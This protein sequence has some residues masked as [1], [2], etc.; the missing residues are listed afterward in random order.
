MISRDEAA[1]EVNFGT[2]NELIGDIVA[3]R[4]RGMVTSWFAPWDNMIRWWGVQ[5]AMMDLVLKPDLV[6]AA[7]DRLVN[8]YLAMLDQWENLNVLS[9]TEGNYRVGSGGYAYTRAIPQEGFDPDHVR[10]IDQWGCATAQIFSEVSPEMHEEFALRYER[11]WLE[12]FGITYY[13]CCE[14]LHNKLDILKSVPNL[15]KISMSPWADVDKCI[16]GTEGKYVLSHKPNPAILAEDNWHPERAREE[17]K[18]VLE[19]TRGACVEVI[20]KDISTLREDPQRLW[21]WADIAV[22]VCEQ[23]GGE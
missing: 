15:R 7:M 17:L 23:Y 18:R 14:P 9:L 2:L 16:E 8:A 19:K 20:L 6:H 22:S 21:E 4:K 10:L 11:R 1:D 12:R 13:G 3:V 5:Q